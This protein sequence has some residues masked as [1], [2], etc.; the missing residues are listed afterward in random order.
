MS[1]MT[2]HGDDFLDT[3]ICRYICPN[4]TEAEAL[5]QLREE[6]PEERCS[7]SYDC[8]AN[9]YRRAPRILHFESGYIIFLL[10]SYLNI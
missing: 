10:R 1:Q 6:Y 7:H 8:C 4:L 3:I 2:H 5:A 9:Y